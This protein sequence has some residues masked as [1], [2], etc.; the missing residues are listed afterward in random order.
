MTVGIVIFTRLKVDG[1]CW[2]NG[3]ELSA[4]QA[5]VGYAGGVGVLQVGSVRGGSADL[6]TS[7]ATSVYKWRWAMRPGQ[8]QHHNPDNWYEGDRNASD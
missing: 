5:E 6:F 1:N 7:R 2:F 3:V 4:R 8:R